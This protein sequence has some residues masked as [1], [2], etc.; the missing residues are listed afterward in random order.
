MDKGGGSQYLCCFTVV[1]A[2][3]QVPVALLFDKGEQVEEGIAVG[4]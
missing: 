1:G 2:M 4:L 3:P